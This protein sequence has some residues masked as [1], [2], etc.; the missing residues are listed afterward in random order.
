MGPQPKGCAARHRAGPDVVVLSLSLVLGS[1][2]RSAHSSESGVTP[3]SRPP[4]LKEENSSWQLSG[5]VAQWHTRSPG[6]M[7]KRCAGPIEI[8]VA[9]CVDIFW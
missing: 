1:G 9:G 6:E 2:H 5:R 3:S 8:D 4:A 7:T